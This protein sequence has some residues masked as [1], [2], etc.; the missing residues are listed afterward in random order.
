MTWERWRDVRPTA[1][2]SGLADEFRLHGRVLPDVEDRRT[3]RQ[4]RH[5]LFERGPRR[6]VGQH[7]D[8]RAVP[9]HVGQPLGRVAGIKRHI[10]AAGLVDRDQA[11]HHLEAALGAD[12]D[13]VVGPHAEGAQ[14]MGKT[15]GAGV[16]FGVG[17]PFTV[18]NDRDRIGRPRDLGFDEFVH[19]F[20]VRIVGLGR[21][22]LDQHP[23]PLG[24]VEL[25]RTFGFRRLAAASG[26]PPR[27]ATRLRA[28]PRARRA[29]DDRHTPME[30][31]ELLQHTGPFSRWAGRSRYWP[32]HA[33][34]SPSPC[35]GRRARV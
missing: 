28:R 8:R 18:A 31:P 26:P 11:H 13:P 2:G 35:P 32:R 30:A 20:V 22:P 29:I 4:R 16:E 27:S 15:V 34:G 21:V 23:M 24:G 12:R 17:Q 3:M 5:A 1:A 19:A 6:A 14:M 25:R 9:E 33:L 10:G 7:R